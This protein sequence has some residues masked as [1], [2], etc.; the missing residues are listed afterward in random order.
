VAKFLSERFL[1]T[2]PLNRLS[3]SAAYGVAPKEP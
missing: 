3:E 2:P 1:A